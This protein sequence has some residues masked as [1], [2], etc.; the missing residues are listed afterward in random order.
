MP[1]YITLAEAARSLPN[2]PS[3]TTLWR[4][5]AKGVAGVRLQTWRIGKQRVTT[6][7]AVAEF[8]AAVTAAAEPVRET[9]TRSPQVAKQLEAAGVL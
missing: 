1:V 5:H 3:P 7:E 6:A 4:W 2:K 9:E 8:I